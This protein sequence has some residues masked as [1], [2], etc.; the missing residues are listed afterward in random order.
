VVETDPDNAVV[1][2]EMV[3]INVVAPPEVVETWIIVDII[4]V[5][6]PPVVR[7]ASSE[8]SLYDV[9]VDV[10]L[11]VPGAKVDVVTP[12]VVGPDVV[13]DVVCVI[14]VD[15]DIVVV[16][17]EDVVG[18]CVVGATVVVTIDLVVDG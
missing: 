3:V 13:D 15:G 9:L 1:E 10:E 12:V 8:E 14:V 4:V 18:A 7:D 11:L 6:D 16:P 17:L 5:E 2:T